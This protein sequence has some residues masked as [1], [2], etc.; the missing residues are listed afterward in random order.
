MDALRRKFIMFWAVVRYHVKAMAFSRTKLI[1]DIA[2][3]LFRVLILLFV[4]MNIYRIAPQAGTV[5]PYSSALWSIGAYFIALAFSARRMFKYVSDLIYTGNIETY[6]VRP[7]HVLLFQAA[8]LL[9]DSLL[10][11]FVTLITVVTVLLIFVGAPVN[12]FSFMTFVGALVLL[13]GGVLIEVLIAATIG[14][15]AIWLENATPV[16]WIADK[17]ILILGGSYVPVAFFP[18]VLKYV[19]MYSPFGATRF[20]SYAFY[21][22]FLEKLWLYGVVQLLWLLVLLVGVIWLFRKGQYRLFVNGS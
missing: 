5:L 8:K 15:F 14:L 16:Y 9:G 22:D 1:I 4:Y 11:A 13:T 12:G 17:L 19:S 6:L 2:M 7:L 20:V 18:D 10:Q 3:T 21:P